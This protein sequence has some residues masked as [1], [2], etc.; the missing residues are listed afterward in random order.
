MTDPFGDLR[1]RNQR[2]KV[3]VNEMLG[4]LDKLRA[5]AGELQQKVRDLKVTVTSDDGFVKV[6][7]GPQGHLEELELNPRIYRRPDSTELARTIT[8]TVKRATA[9]MQQKVVEL[10]K[11]FMPEADV[12]AHMKGDHEGIVNRLEGRL[13]EGFDRS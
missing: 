3:R 2:M 1:E 11:P 6:T 13:S 4:E 5:N 9:E 10:Y 12:L 7:V 8:D